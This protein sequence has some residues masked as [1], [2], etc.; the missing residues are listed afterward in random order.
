MRRGRAV[1][2]AR[3]ARTGLV[4]AMGL[5]VACAGARGPQ[6][7]AREP[8]LRLSELGALGDPARRA[9]MR[10]VLQGLDADVARAPAAALASYERA[11]QV[12][13]NNPWAWLALARHE[14]EQGQPARALAGLDKAEALLPGEGELSR[15]AAPHRIGLRGAA[16]HAARASG[17][18]TQAPA[19]LE[20]ARRLAPVVWADGVL[21]A[22]ELR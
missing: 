10:L 4:F 5:L 9:S 15:G 11:L 16:L 6:P 20:D 19:L 12:D 21:D 22:S 13:P 8:A 2:A 7:P 17:A 14:L 1:S 3:L 18:T